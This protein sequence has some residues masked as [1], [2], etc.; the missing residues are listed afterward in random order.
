MRRFFIFDESEIVVST[1]YHLEDKE[2]YH[3]IVNVLRMKRYDK[4]EIVQNNKAVYEAEIAEITKKNIRFKINSLVS[5]IPKKKREITLFQ[6]M[7][8]LKKP[9]LIVQKTSEIGI[10]NIVFLQTERTD[11]SSRKNSAKKIERLSK[12]SQSAAEQSRRYDIADVD[13]IYTIDEIKSRLEKYDMVFLFDEA[14]K[15]KT[16]KD[17]EED[18]KSAKSIAL[19]VGPEGGFDDKDR[20]KLRDLSKSISLGNKILRTETAGIYVLS[21][22]DYIL[23]YDL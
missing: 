9:E 10:S 7:P 8:K 13:G 23:N 11:F 14:A 2:Q 21:Q 1:I 20:E 4:L 12:I 19:I 15:D 16:L 22:L 5:K 18:I 3:R 17:Y 6:S